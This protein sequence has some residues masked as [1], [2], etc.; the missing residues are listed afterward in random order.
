MI[1]VM[2]VDARIDVIGFSRSV[3]SIVVLL[4]FGILV[5]NGSSWVYAWP[6]FLGICKGA[7][8]GLFL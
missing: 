4:A 1:D 3:T 6:I 2:L 7:G 5:T 8:L